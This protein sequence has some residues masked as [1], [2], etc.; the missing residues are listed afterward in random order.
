MI[1]LV[2]AATA[3]IAK[4]KTQCVEVETQCL[5]RKSVSVEGLSQ[6]PYCID[7]CMMHA[8]CRGEEEVMISRATGLLETWCMMIG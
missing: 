8:R 7:G 1:G 6:L 3:G 4:D 2:D 5:A